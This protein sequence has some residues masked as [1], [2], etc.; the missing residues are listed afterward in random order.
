M[1]VQGRK[2]IGKREKGKNEFPPLFWIET[3]H[4][5]PERSLGNFAE[6][7]DDGVGSQ[8]RYVDL[9]GRK[10]ER[11]NVSVRHSEAR[12]TETRR[13]RTH[14]G[15]ES[16]NERLKLSRIEHP[17]PTR[18]DDIGAANNKRRGREVSDEVGFSELEEQK[19][20]SPTRRREKTKRASARRLRGVEKT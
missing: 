15:I 11:R 2:K 10:S 1:S 3:L 7:M 4:D 8:I 17:D 16:S 12:R 6:S 14:L 5:R 9:K 18:V 19:T 13:A 20:N